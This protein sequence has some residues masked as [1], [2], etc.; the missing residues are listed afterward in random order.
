MKKL[1]WFQLLVFSEEQHTFSYSRKRSCNSTYLLGIIISVDCSEQ[2][3]SS[4]Y[5][6]CP[7]QLRDDVNWTIIQL[8]KKQESNCYSP[9]CVVYVYSVNYLVHI[10]TTTANQVGDYHTH[11][12]R[13]HPLM[14]AGYRHKTI[15]IPG[16]RA[17]H[18]L[19]TLTNGNGYIEDP[20]QFITWE[21]YISVSMATHLVIGNCEIDHSVPVH[22]SLQHIGT[23]GYCIQDQLQCKASKYRL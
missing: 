19:L 1:V 4:C 17:S 21:W 7:T 5:L 20:H 22:P 23:G 18:N 16:Y 8:R 13:P 12:P 2:C 11:M 3:S 9:F 6:A 10:P 14:Q 15:S